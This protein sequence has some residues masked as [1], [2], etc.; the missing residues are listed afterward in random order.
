MD[1]P[2]KLMGRLM[3]DIAA[4]ADDIQHYVRRPGADFTRMRCLGAGDVIRALVCM[5]AGTLDYELDGFLEAP[6]TCTPSA[7]SQQRAKIE[8]EALRQLL[9]RFK[10]DVATRPVREEGLR[11]VTVDGSEV[12]MQ[13]NPRDE[14]TYNPKANG[15]TELGYNS[16]Y[17][18]ALLD[19]S[20]GAFLDAVVQP[21]SQKDESAA[22][23]VLADRCDPAF[24]LVGDRGFAS[25]NNFAHCLERGVGFIIRLTDAFAARLLET[26][27]LPDKVDRTVD[28]LLT[29]SQHASLRAQPG[30]RFVSRNMK[31]DFLETEGVYRMRLRVVRFAI[32]NDGFENLA[33]SLGCDECTLKELREIYAERWGI[34]I[35]FRDLKHTLGLARLHSSTARG[36]A[37]EVYARM[38]LYNFCLAM[39]A[40][41]QL[42]VK[43]REGL[44]HAYAINFAAAVRAC[45]AVLWPRAG[46]ADGLLER[47][48]AN[49]CP[50]RPGRSFARHRRLWSPGNYAYRC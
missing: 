1:T 31:F 2:G 22:F 16:V 36:A 7:F 44:K 13:R 3:S 33:C 10:P 12:V 27:I 38:V 17:L 42:L 41:A 50:I 45:R 34:E 48:A 37:Q 11:L 4:I 5:G 43:P 49:V 9:L 19:M 18:T 20:G 30:Y 6:K 29:R 28:L 26:D 14:E 15:H 32:G 40:L 35:A 47:I 39:T 46:P 24:V 21:S 8:P 25:Y 23:R